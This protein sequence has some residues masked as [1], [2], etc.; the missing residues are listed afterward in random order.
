MRE[1]KR[2]ELQAIGAVAKL[3]ILGG[4][5]VVLFTSYLDF[6]VSQFLD[7]LPGTL[8][9]SPFTTLLGGTIALSLGVALRVWLWRVQKRTGISS[10]P[11][12][13]KG[14]N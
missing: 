7:G 6:N 1:W 14:N 3:M 8:V 9:T 5:F 12:D 13:R 11:F 2:G 10:Q 4:G